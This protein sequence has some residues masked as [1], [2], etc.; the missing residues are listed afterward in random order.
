VFRGVE[1][2]FVVLRAVSWWR[3]VFRYVVWCFAFL[4]AFTWCVGMPRSVSEGL[5]VS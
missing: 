1:L 4:R 3:L 2:C 5:E